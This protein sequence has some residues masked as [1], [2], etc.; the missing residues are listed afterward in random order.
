M[1]T[2]RVVVVVV[3]GKA[4]KDRNYVIVALL[5]RPTSE[6]TINE[7]SHFLSM[8]RKEAR[9]P[10]VRKLETAL[11]R[12]YVSSRDGGCFFKSAFLANSSS[13]GKRKQI[14]STR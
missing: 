6:G 3:I 2:V 4:K 1:R 8:P 10:S 12:D 14:I 7:L 5:E 9:F 11:L 13:R